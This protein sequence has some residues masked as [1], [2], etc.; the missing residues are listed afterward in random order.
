MRFRGLLC[1]SFRGGRGAGEN[2]REAPR[3]QSQP[4][5]PKNACTR[6][7]LCAAGF[8]VPFLLQKRNNE[9]VR[10]EQ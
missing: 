3:V 10:G 9:G 1:V 5:S 6:V 7:D 2:R 4:R 8:S